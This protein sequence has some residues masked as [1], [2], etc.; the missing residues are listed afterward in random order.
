MTYG[1]VRTGCLGFCA[2]EVLTSETRY[3]RILLESDR[4]GSSVVFPTY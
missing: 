3:L 4:F 2:L 1:K